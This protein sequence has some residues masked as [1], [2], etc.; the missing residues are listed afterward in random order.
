MPDWPTAD[1]RAFATSALVAATARAS[2]KQAS[3]ALV[4]DVKFGEFRSKFRRTAHDEDEPVYAPPAPLGLT[5]KGPDRQVGSALRPGGAHATPE[6][7]SSALTPRYWDVA[8]RETK[9]Q[10][11]SRPVEPDWSSRRQQ[12][13]GQ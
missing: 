1:P 13:G 7:T 8:D 9:S 5:Q 2:N 4:S 10:M 12:L 6:L 3:R 11:C